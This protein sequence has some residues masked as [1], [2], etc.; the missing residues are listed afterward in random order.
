MSGTDVDAVTASYAEGVRDG[1][2]QEAEWVAL[3][4]VDR[5]IWK[6]RA[7]KAEAELFAAQQALITEGVAR[8]KAEAEVN[9][10]RTERDDLL[11]Y[12]EVG[13]LGDRCA[14][15]DRIEARRAAEGRKG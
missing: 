14:I 8:N 4:T 11:A 13:P 5:D 1:R 15:I 2:K 7:E 10:L 9:D 12:Y 6:S 3:I